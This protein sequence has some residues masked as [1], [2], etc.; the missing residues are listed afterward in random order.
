[1]NNKTLAGSLRILGYA[2]IALMA[3]ALLYAS[4]ISLANWPGIAV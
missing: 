2:V 4:Y 3:A 1:M